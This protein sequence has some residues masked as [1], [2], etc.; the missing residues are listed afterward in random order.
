MK[1][2]NKVWLLEESIC[3]ENYVLR[4]VFSSKA[5]AEKEK[6]RLEKGQRKR[7]ENYCTW[8]VTEQEVK[9]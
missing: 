3:F 6:R 8:V 2:K 9:P 4:D 1:T 5:G 7:R